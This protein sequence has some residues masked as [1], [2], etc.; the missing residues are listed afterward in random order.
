MTLTLWWLGLLRVIVDLIRAAAWP[1]V[2]LM[3]FLAIRKPL[4]ERVG[5][6]QKLDV[7]NILKLQ[8]AE[9]KR[10]QEQLIAAKTRA[11]NCVCSL[12]PGRSSPLC[13]TPKGGPTLL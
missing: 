7:K 5:A 1:A 8:F 6:L 4:L 2:T 12:T 13:T 11:D 10:R 9:Q 3:A